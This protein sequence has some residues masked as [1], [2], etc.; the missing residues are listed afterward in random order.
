MFN[1]YLLGVKLMATATYSAIQIIYKSFTWLMSGFKNAYTFIKDVISEKSII[2]P[3]Q[4]MMERANETTTETWDDIKSYIIATFEVMGN[5]Y[6][7][8]LKSVED[9]TNAHKK[10]MNIFFGLEEPEREGGRAGTAEKEQAKR[11]AEALKQFWEQY[12]DFKIKQS[13]EASKKESYWSAV[14]TQEELQMEVAKFEEM[15]N[16]GEKWFEASLALYAKQLLAH[17]DYAE[18]SVEYEKALNNKRRELN[19]KRVDNEISDLNK[20]ATEEDKI[21]NERLYKEAAAANT[22]R[23]LDEK[24]TQAR[25]DSAKTFFDRLKALMESDDLKK[26]FEVWADYALSQVNRIS[27]GIGTAFA[28]A[29]VEG[30]NLQEELDKVW[31]GIVSDLIRELTSEALKGVIR[32]LFK[33]ADNG[34]VDWMGL[35]GTVLVWFSGG[36]E[37]SKG[38]EVWVHSGGYVKDA[39]SFHS[40]GL[41]TNE[42][43][44]KL[45]TDEFVMGPMATKK[46]GVNNLD[47]INR[48]GQL[49]GQQERPQVQVPV[50]IINVADP[51]EIAK[52]LIENP[53][54]IVNAIVR[55]KRFHGEI[56]R[57]IQER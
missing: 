42:V 21:R 25:I 52:Y 12:Y 36:S 28:N 46:I 34:G 54:I 17:K 19:A 32:N 44:A 40:G 26:P 7:E 33:D 45:R 23:Q 13:R 3:Y 57:M 37:S 20:V 5:D 14:W 56:K 18:G 1:T 22:Q 51:N 30:K 48:T 55:D 29:I 6:E 27:D 2:A 50:Q 15:Q 16:Y 49:A 9:T 10:R 53:N 8:Y 47:E 41:N 35:I 4:R 38:K 24:A 11:D 39:P 31:K 43:M